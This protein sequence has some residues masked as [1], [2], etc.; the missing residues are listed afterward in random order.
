MEKLISHAFSQWDLATNNLVTTERVEEECADYSVFVD[1]VRTA[2]KSFAM[3]TD[4]PGIPT[5]DSQIAAHARTVLK[6]FDQS[7]IEST[8]RRRDARLNEVL[9]IDDD[10]TDILVKVKVFQEV[11]VQVGHG[12]CDYACAQRNGTTVDIRFLGSK[13]QISNLNVPGGDDIADA[14][15]IPFNS[16]DPVDYRYTTLVHE[17]GHALGITGGPTGVDQGEFHPDIKDSVMSYSRKR[18]ASCS[19]LPF[20]IMAMY[21]LYQTVD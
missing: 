13:F 17:A 19:P 8:K 2:V 20:D 12:W 3:G 4:I 15:E 16:C 14:G 18:A 11:S 5:T 9:M 6:N 21:A 1:E 10:P 7:G